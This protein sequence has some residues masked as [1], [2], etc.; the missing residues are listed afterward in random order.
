MGFFNKHF[1]SYDE[2]SQ[3]ERGKKINEKF[4]LAAEENARKKA[5]WEKN[6]PPEIKTQIKQFQILFA[7]FFITFCIADFIGLTVY[8]YPFVIGC[9]AL[10]GLVSF[11]LCRTNPFKVKYP[12]NFFMPTLAFFI[13]ICFSLCIICISFNYEFK[14]AVM[15]NPPVVPT[16]V[17]E[18]LEK[19]EEELL[20]EK[21][22]NLSESEFY[23]REYSQFLKENNVVTEGKIEENNQNYKN[24]NTKNVTGE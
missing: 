11:I 1:Q 12:S 23:E 22:N 7:T 2:W 14:R 17:M 15:I 3:T 9:Q 5:E 19:T 8:K 6:T 4:R 13:S 16:E 18:T 21:E 24:A 20:I 10:I